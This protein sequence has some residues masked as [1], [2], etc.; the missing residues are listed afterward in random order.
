MTT[1]PAAWFPAVPGEPLFVAGATLGVDLPDWWRP[2]MLGNGYVT[3]SA[4]GR[5]SL[6][7][8]AG[9]LT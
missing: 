8:T 7:Q 5:R 4:P 2:F 6:N 9:F 3:V 1:D